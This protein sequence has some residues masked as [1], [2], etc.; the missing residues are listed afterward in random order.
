MVILI[1]IVRMC[2]PI[3]AGGK[4]ID[5]G[6]KAATMVKLMTTADGTDEKKKVTAS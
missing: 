5:L 4:T 2:S 6:V 3:L 1:Q